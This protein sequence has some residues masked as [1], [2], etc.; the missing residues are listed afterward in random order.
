METPKVFLATPMYGGM[1]TGVY[2]QSIIQLQ[3]VFQQLQWPLMCSFM[4]N[5]SLITRARNA[6]AHGFL[7][8][9]C[10]HLFFIDA[11][12]RWDS[13]QVPQMFRS[14]KPIIAGIYPK[15]EVNW[16]SVKNAMRNGVKN[17][18]LKYHTG[19]H[20]INLESYAQE[21]TVPIHKPAKVWNCGTGFMLIQRHVLERM[22][23]IVPKYKND[24]LDLSGGMQQG[25]EI[26]EFFTTSIEPETGRLLSEDY[27]F[28]RT[29]R[30]KL[31]GEIYV[32][33]W[34]QLAHLGSY[35]FEGQLIRN[36]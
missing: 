30:H 18:E 27:H 26:S 2:T 16:D 21:V 34:V 13:M 7:K 24:V 32:A 6:M 31:D 8:T 9:D 10:T 20:V 1:C 29:W 33:P 4:F 3:G 17:E 11:D 14:D 15:K 28:C 25:E 12:I 35:C 19:S 36:P 23:E 5:E 22:R